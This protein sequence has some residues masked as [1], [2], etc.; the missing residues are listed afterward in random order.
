LLL[1]FNASHNAA[2]TASGKAPANLA[3]KSNSIGT[4]QRS[5]RASRTMPANQ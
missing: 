2:M 5:V 3:F 4:A 1:L